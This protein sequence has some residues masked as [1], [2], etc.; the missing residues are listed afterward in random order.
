MKPAPVVGTISGCLIWFL[1]MAIV[2]PI[3]FGLSQF[4][5]AFTNLTGLAK[6]I[7]TPLVCP[8]GTGVRV[9]VVPS[10]YVD[11]NGFESPSVANEFN[12]VDGKGQLV[13]DKTHEQEFLWNA[14]VAGAS[15]ILSVLFSFL[16]AAP[17]GLFI[18]RLMGIFKRPQPNQG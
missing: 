17:F 4:V 14:I 5:G 13:A 8:A 12:C 15:L 11:S 16:F 1:L 6:Q 3:F 18:D 2:A 10:T 9:D 7:T